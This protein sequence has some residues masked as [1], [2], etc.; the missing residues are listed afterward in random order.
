[1]DTYREYEQKIKDYEPTEA[2]KKT[3]LKGKAQLTFKKR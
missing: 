1:M 3:I 2:D